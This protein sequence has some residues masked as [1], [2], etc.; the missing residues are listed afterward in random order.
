MMSQRSLMKSR[1]KLG[2][3]RFLKNKIIIRLERCLVTVNNYYYYRTI[4]TKIRRKITKRKF[5]TK[6]GKFGNQNYVLDS[7]ED[8]RYVLHQGERFT[9]MPKS[10]VPRI[11]ENEKK[12]IGMRSL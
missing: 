11:K 8:F 9:E 3:V 4:E 2:Q 7:L 12:N 1:K 5:D 10:R 6:R